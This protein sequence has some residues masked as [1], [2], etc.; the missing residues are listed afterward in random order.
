MYYSALVK[1]AKKLVFEAHKADF[2][3]GGY[4]YVFHPFYLATQV[5]GEF[6]TCVALLHDVIEDHGDRYAFDD[7]LASGFPVEVVEAL[8]LLTHK[9]R[10]AYLDYIKAISKNPLARAVKIEDLKHNLDI[11][12]TEGKKAVK[13]ALYKEA[14]DFLEADGG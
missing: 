1:K 11:S 7:F 9:K 2:D 12:R 8:R 6:A 3:K 14:L 5:K 4:P 13:H 10:V